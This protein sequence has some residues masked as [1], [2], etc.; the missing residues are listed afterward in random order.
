MLARLRGGA[1]AP[2][3]ALPGA[4]Y[5]P[6]MSRWLY[7]TLCTVTFAVLMMLVVSPGIHWAV[8]SYW[9]PFVRGLNDFWTGVLAVVM[10]SIF[11]PG[12]I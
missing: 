11:V 9:A 8:D 2:L 10:V 4:P 5:T 7:V 6:T 1:R 12:M 3:P